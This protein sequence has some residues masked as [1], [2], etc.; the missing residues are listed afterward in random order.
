MWLVISLY[1]KNFLLIFNGSD[2]G[3]KTKMFWT[4]SQTAAI[5]FQYNQVI[6]DAQFLS[7]FTWTTGDKVGVS[8]DRILNGK[9]LPVWYFSVT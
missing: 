8:V 2:S 6:L 3:E 5:A 7:S 4:A 1:E 9:K